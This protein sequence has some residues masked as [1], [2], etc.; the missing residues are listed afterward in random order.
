MLPSLR[1][2]WWW[3]F[4]IIAAA[5]TITTTTTTVIDADADAMEI[6]ERR[7]TIRR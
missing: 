7:N 4:A 1:C 3:H 5:V 6:A 2:C